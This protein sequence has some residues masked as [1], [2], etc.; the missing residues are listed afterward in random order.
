LAALALVSPVQNIVFLASHFFT[1]LVLIAQQPV[2]Q[3]VVLG[4]LYLCLWFAASYGIEG[5]VFALVDLFALEYSPPYR[6]LHPSN[7][8]ACV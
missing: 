6:L 3:A 2:G 8:Q 7:C 1:L 4:R 5:F